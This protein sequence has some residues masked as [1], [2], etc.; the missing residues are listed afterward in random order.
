MADSAFEWA[1]GRGLVR[2]NPVHGEQE[3]KLVLGDSFCF[4]EETG[5]SRTEHVRM[6]IEDESGG[7]FQEN[8][9]PLNSGV[10]SLLQLGEDANREGEDVALQSSG[11]FKLVFPAVQENSSA[12]AVHANQ[13][14]IQLNTMK[15]LYDGL[16]TLQKEL[17]VNRSTTT[18]KAV[19]GVSGGKAKATSSRSPKGPGGNNSG[20]T[21]PARKVTKPKKANPA[22]ACLLHVLETEVLHGGKVLKYTFTVVSLKGDWPFLRSSMALNNGYNCKD[23]CHRCNLGLKDSFLDQQEWWDLKGAVKRLRPYDVNPKPFKAERSPLRDLAILEN[24]K[25]IRID[26]AHTFAIDGVGKNFAGTAILLLMH[27]GWF[28]GGNTDYKFQYAYSRFMAYCD[29]RQKSTSIYEFSYKTLK[30][31]IGSLRGTP[32][33]LGKGHDCAIV[34]AWLDEEL[35]QMDLESVA[36]EFRDIMEVLVWGCSSINRF[37]RCMYANG[38]WLNRLQVENMVQDGWAF[39]DGYATLARQS[40]KFGM[41]GCQIRPKA[42][43]F[44][45]L[46]LDLE[47]MLSLEC[48]WVLNPATHCTWSDEDFIG[49]VSR[50]SRRSHVL[51]C[52]LHTIQRCLGL[53]RRQWIKEFH[54]AVKQ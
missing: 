8:L 48:E 47:E 26:P 42:H 19:K 32:R 46:L 24:P 49:R 44:C 7:I 11:S 22:M 21:K 40:C 10:E 54:P 17:A 35:Q 15:K 34:T 1:S 13:I 25:F 41:V 2:V 9:P 43:M 33:G 14:S 38:V 45:H 31:P 12:M 39:V 36:V 30:L 53:Y 6:E 37:W 27:M 20:K 52:A 23:K 50:V 51:T 16:E 3:A 5:V 4:K 28:G 29:A 18:I